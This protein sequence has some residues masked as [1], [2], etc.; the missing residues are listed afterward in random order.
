MTPGG[1]KWDQVAASIRAAMDEQ[2]LTKADLLRL[3]GITRPTLNSYLAGNPIGSLKRRW[4]ICEALG[5]TD[6][7]IDL[8][9]QG[10]QPEPHV[11]GVAGPT[12]LS[13]V[14]LNELMVLL[15][16]IQ[17][18]QRSVIDEIGRKLQQLSVIDEIGRNPRNT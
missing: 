8:I 6:D 3:A 18:R 2:H 4:A 16:E 11:A 15:D 13:D 14:D 1:E 9:L 5:W 7:S 10:G 17:L 12:G